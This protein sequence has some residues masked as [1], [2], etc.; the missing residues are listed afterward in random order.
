MCECVRVL[1]KPLKTGSKIKLINKN[2]RLKSKREVGDTCG[3]VFFFFKY[4]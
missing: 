3:N 1:G 2:N 4:K